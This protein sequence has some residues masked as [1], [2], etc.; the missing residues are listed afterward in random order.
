MSH[1]PQK[2]AK[3]VT[4]VVTAVTLLVTV[5]V[6]A[7]VQDAGVPHQRSESTQAMKPD[8]KKVYIVQMAEEPVATYQG[9]DSRFAATKP[10]VGQKIEFASQ[11]VTRAC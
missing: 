5:D 11:A 4:A 9:G 1:S 7:V 6:G 3:V 2:S 10:K 8:A